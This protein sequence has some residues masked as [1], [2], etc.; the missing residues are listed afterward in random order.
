MPSS[1]R[2]LRVVIPAR[3][4]SQR[5]PEKP[6]IDLGGKPM[7][8]R[9]FEAVRKGFGGHDIV[10]AVDDLRI[11]AVLDAYQIPGTMTSPFCKS[12]TDR[13][14]EVARVRMWRPDDI[15]VN[16]QGDE[17]LVPPDLLSAFA[18][19]CLKRA[20]FTMATVSVPVNELREITDPN[21]VKLTVDAEGSAIS[22]S[23]SPVPFDR[24]HEPEAWDPAN[25]RRHLGI[26]AY[27]S[28]V[29]QRLS[30]TPPCAI[31]QVESLEQLRALW[32]RIPIHVMD[33]HSAPPGGVDT[34]QDVKRVTAYITGR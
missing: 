6:L 7:I 15:V 34:A 3:L 27:R 31:E 13:V 12:G 32:L 30:A 14:A 33:W 28:D 17:P 20:E 11:M 23:R 1:D 10:V 25:Y 21:V 18:D 22:F 24:D 16:V 9:V 4:H 29:L 2:A 5:L 19:F 8:V 26:Y